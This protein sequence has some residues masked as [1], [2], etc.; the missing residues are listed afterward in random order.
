[1][2][3]S[4]FDSHAEPML[5]SATISRHQLQV[6]AVILAAYS[7][8]LSVG[9]QSGSHFDSDDTLYSE[10]ARQMVESGNWADNQWGE[11]IQFEK[12]PLYLWSLAVSGGLFG[13]SE[14]AMRIPGTLFALGALAALYLL[15]LGLGSTTQQAVFSTL[16]LASSYFFILM[17]RRLMMDLPM[18]ACCLAGAAAVTRSSF[19][20]FGVF[21]GLAV[22]IKGAAAGPLL[23]ALFVFAL[24]T[25]VFTRRQIVI[26]V[27]T[28]IAVA[29][30]WHIVES[31]RYGSEF[32]SVYLFHHVG[33]RATSN[34]VP[35]LTLAQLL[36]ALLLDA[37]LCLLALLGAMSFI[38][39]A[40]RPT[41]VF[42]GLWL[43]LALLPVLISSTRLPHY[44]L[45]ALVPLVMICAFVFVRPN[46]SKRRLWIMAGAVVLIQM[47]VPA[48]KFW[49]W[50][51]PDFAPSH[52]AIASV[53]KE[54]ADTDDYT[55]T[56]NTTTNAL[57]FYT[58]RRFDMLTTDERFYEIQEPLFLIRRAG[59]LKRIGESGISVSSPYSRRFIVARKQVDRRA[60][61]NSMRKAHPD[62]EL[63]VLE[64]PRLE[65]VNDGGLGEPI[66]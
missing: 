12:P 53:L 36:D 41:L 55:A 62:R 6:L 64:G 52:K 66:P 32:W 23:V 56:F 42:A 20:L 61:V 2:S 34:I 43:V 46:D 48:Q 65:V 44:L 63:H 54:A 7:L 11:A 47:A 40:L 58:D 15:M 27:C 57:T 4:N 49:I 26:A 22:L 51:E 3:H 38:R 21:S 1:M 14:A 8:F 39:K 29:A 5:K 13:W 10:M 24:W 37:P 50:Y 31:M 16:F 35:G 33:E 60:V 28:G 25:R 9:I 45:P 18:L 30:P 59:V 17:A 19:I